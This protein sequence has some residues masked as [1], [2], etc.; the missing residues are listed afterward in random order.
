M[1]KVDCSHWFVE[2]RQFYSVDPFVTPKGLVFHRGDEN[3]QTIATI[4]HS[5]WKFDHVMM[6]CMSTTVATIARSK[7]DNQAIRQRLNRLM[8]ATYFRHSDIGE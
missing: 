1:D 6:A 4:K 2:P 8:W 7:P 3:C 5:R